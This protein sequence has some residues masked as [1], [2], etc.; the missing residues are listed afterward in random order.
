MDPELGEIDVLERRIEGAV[1]FI[2]GLKKR[3]EELKTKLRALEDENRRLKVESENLGKAREE[4]R[5]KVEAL[6]EKL[7]LIE[8]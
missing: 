4:A 6:I 3:E 2:D 5:D 1:Q 7:K 8:G